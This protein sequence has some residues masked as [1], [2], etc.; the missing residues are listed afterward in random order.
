MAC[1]T[2]PLPMDAIEQ[3]GMLWPPK[4]GATSTPEE[5]IAA[6]RLFM[7]VHEDGRWNP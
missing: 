5:F 2:P 6:R 4:R 7:D 3:D 1:T